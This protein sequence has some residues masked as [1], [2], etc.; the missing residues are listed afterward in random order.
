MSDDKYHTL[1]Y[2]QWY[3]FGGGR[4]KLKKPLESCYCVSCKTK[5]TNI[6]IYWKKVSPIS[7]RWMLKGV[8]SVCNKN[9]S[10]FVMPRW[11]Y[12]LKEIEPLL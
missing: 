7:N 9:T 2:Y 8:C 11:D 12:T 1:E 3:W 10:K 6:K 4:E 5:T